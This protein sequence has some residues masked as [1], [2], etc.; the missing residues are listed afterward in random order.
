MKLTREQIIEL[1]AL[2]MIKIGDPNARR[3]LHWVARLIK[4]EDEKGDA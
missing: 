3:H 2:R 1:I 4:Q